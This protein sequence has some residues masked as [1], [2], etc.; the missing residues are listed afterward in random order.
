MSSSEVKESVRIIRVIN[1]HL[2]EEPECK[3]SIRDIMREA[4]EI[5]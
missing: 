1:Q 4:I 3:C 5:A 2:A